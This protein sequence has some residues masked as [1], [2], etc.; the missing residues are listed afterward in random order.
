MVFIRTDTDQPVY[1]ATY[2]SVAIAIGPYIV[3]MPVRDDVS[4]Y[5][6]VS[7][8]YRRDIRSIQ[9]RRGGLCR[10]LRKKRHVKRALGYESIDDAWG[11]R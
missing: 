5:Q 7:L 1:R 8:V 4:Q 11:V 3:R 9:Q 2:T 6:R 10:R